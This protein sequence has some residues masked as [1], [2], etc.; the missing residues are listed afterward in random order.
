MC[1]ATLQ[2]CLNVMITEVCRAFV[3]QTE[4]LVWWLTRGKKFSEINIYRFRHSSSCFL[5]NTAS[6]G[7][8]GVQNCCPIWTT[9]DLMGSPVWLDHKK[10][11]LEG[12][13]ISVLIYFTNLY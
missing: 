10:F 8:Q 12:C 4:D 13:L 1:F 5:P 9:P 2:I 3:L 11:H 7:E 6:S